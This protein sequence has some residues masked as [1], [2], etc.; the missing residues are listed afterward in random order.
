MHGTAK[1]EQPKGRNGSWVEIC[2]R[3]QQQNATTRFHVMKKN[4]ASSVSSCRGGEGYFVHRTR[5]RE[6][7]VLATLFCSCSLFER[8]SFC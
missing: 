2:R 1:K 3:Q 6:W 5:T 7:H 8:A 4:A